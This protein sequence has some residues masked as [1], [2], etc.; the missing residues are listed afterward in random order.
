MDTNI[1]CNLTIE[2]PSTEHL[3]LSYEIEQEKALRVDMAANQQE[4]SRPTDVNNEA[5]P[6]HVQYEDDVINIQLL[7][8][9]QAS[10]EP[11]LWSG[12]NHSISFHGSIEHFISDS[13]N[14]KVTLNF[15]AKYIQ[16]KQVNGGKVNNLDDFNGMGDAIWN[17]ISAVYVA[18]WDALFTDQKS[19]T[20]SAKIF[21]KFTSQ[22]PST[23]NNNKKEIPKSIPIS[24]NRTLPLPPLLAKSKKESMSSPNISNPRSPQS[25]T[26]L[27]I[28]MSKPENHT[29]RLP[30]L[31]SIPLKF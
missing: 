17:F 4:T 19:N 6:L 15:L 10:T 14:I 2:E 7:Y 12:K 11:E 23:N 26:M 25:R 18:R 5:T 9:P 30:K 3:E 1:D 20:L 29:P 24:I 13:K 22:T 28:S 21:S 27:K 8:N 16:N 31:Q